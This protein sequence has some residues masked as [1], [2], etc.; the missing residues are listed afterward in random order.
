MKQF[1]V[2]AFLCLLVTP[3]MAEQSVLEKQLLVKTAEGKSFAY[4]IELALTES[5][6]M[7]GLMFRNELDENAGMLFPFPDSQQRSFWM[8]NTLIPLD[9]IFVKQDGTIQNIGANA[10]PLDLTP[11]SSTGPVKAVLEINGGQAAERGIKPGDIVHH[12]IFGNSLAQ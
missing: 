4:N 5:E 10:V 8:K 12:S 1:L 11:V 9:I 6:Q 2:F 3:C 7:Q